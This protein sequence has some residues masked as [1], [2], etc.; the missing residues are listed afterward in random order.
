M[1]NASH[2]CRSKLHIL[3]HTKVNKKEKCSSGSG[4]AEFPTDSA[5]DGRNESKRLVIGLF[6]C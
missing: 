5:S 4:Q 3:C 1:Q 2:I 6:H